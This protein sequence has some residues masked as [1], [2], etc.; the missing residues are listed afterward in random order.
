MNPDTVSKFRAITDIF[1]HAQTTDAI[2]CAMI[3]H[4]FA[5]SIVINGEW[6]KYGI[7]D[8]NDISYEIFKNFDSLPKVL[9]RAIDNIEELKDNQILNQ[10]RIEKVWS[11]N[12][13]RKFSLNLYK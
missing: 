8:E 5:G 13:L 12:S 3:E 1:I 4:L 9:E 11:W 2:S 7:L 10:S 6:L